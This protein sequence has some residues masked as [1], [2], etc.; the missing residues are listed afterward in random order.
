MAVYQHGNRSIAYQIEFAPFAHDL[1]LLQSS[2]FD[3]GFWQPVLSNLR[4]HTP[5]SGRVIV[6][7]WHDSNLNEAQMAADLVGLLKTLGLNAIHV[8]ACDDAVDVVAEIEKQNPGC[9]ENTLFF[10][11]NVPRPDELSRSIR[12]FSQI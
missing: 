8:V 7:E 3:A 4:D 11:Q 12:E 5:A 2:R 9:F 1:V 6:C 10:A